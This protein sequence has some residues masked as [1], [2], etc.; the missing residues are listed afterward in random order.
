[1]HIDRALLLRT[2]FILG[3][4]HF[5][6]SYISCYGVLPEELVASLCQY[7]NS[8]CLFPA[9]GSQ[10]LQ[11]R[12][13]AQIVFFVDLLIC[14]SWMT[15]E[16][17]LFLRWKVCNPRGIL[18]LFLCVLMRLHLVEDTTWTCP[19]R[20]SFTNEENSPP[21]RRHQNFILPFFDAPRL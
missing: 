15:D 21:L 14:G 9:F 8:L 17:H 2:A 7:R 20:G 1:M 19:L 4:N 18:F 11:V 10:K 5:W 6:N 13:F 12:R 16:S 3:K